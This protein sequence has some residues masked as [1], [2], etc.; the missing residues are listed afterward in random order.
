MSRSP[1]YYYHVVLTRHDVFPMDMLRYAEAWPATAD[2]AAL[3]DILISRD[4]AR[5]QL[6][7][8]TVSI[9]LGSLHRPDPDLDPRFT[10]IK[11]RWESF[12][13]EVRLDAWEGSLLGR[14]ELIGKVDGIRRLMSA[15][16][17]ISPSFQTNTI[18]DACASLAEHLPNVAHYSVRALCRSNRKTED[19]VDMWMEPRA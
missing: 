1:F 10:S 5:L 15:T 16:G 11:Q 8:K 7:P 4:D 14:D 9:R 12:L 17:F 2:D 19:I 6:L 18:D 13:I 3:I